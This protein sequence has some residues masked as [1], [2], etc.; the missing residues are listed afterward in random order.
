MAGVCVKFLRGG[1]G[2][3]GGGVCMYVCVRERGTGV[4]MCVVEGMCERWKDR[5]VTC[6]LS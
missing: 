2:I 3:R 4:C 5:G 6:S 1:G